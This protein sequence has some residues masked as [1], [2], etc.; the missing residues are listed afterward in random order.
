MMWGVSHGVLIE[1]IL[2]CSPHIDCK[3]ESPSRVIHRV[4]WGVSHR[5]MWGVSH[6]VLI[7]SIL[8]CSPHVGCGVFD[9]RVMWGG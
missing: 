5:M 7:E 3:R 1:S 6:G 2:G 4:M 9:G 8:Q